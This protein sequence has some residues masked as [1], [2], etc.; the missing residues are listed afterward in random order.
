VILMNDGRP[1]PTR[2]AEL[3]DACALLTSVLHS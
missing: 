1:M 2:H 3:A